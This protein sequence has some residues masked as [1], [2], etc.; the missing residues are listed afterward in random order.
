MNIS[1]EQLR[2]WHDLLDKSGENTKEQVRNEIGKLFPKAIY[3]SKD[4][5]KEEFIELF[6]KEKLAVWCKTKELDKVLFE[7]VDK[8]KRFMTISYV[9]KNK[10]IW[11]FYKEEICYDLYDSSYSSKSYYETLG[12]TI[13]EFMG[14]K[15]K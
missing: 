12:Y 7:V 13:I 6:V 4:I 8:F 2:K 3:I 9:D 14:Y 1:I 15:D 11:N 5:T 10:N